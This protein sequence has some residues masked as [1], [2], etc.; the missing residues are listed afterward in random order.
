MNSP[1][2]LCSTLLILSGTTRW[3]AQPD[4]TPLVVFP[5]RRFHAVVL[6]GFAPRQKCRTSARRPGHPNDPVPPREALEALRTG[7]IFPSEPCGSSSCKRSCVCYRA[8]AGPLTQPLFSFVTPGRDGSKNSLWA[9]SGVRK[10]CRS[11]RRSHGRQRTGCQPRLI[12][13]EAG[14]LMI[15]VMDARTNRL[16]PAM[17][18]SSPRCMCA[19][20]RWPIEA[21]YRMSS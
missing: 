17:L 10:S 8:A 1:C 9:A 14:T 16:S 4:A 11:H 13:Y 12:E 19:A 20:G 21:C 2:P 18:T 5:A 15:D 7:T 6:S 3:A